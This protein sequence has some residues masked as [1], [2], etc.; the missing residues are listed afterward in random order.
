[1]ERLDRIQKGVERDVLEC[2]ERLFERTAV[3]AVGVGEHGERAAPRAADR[4]DR[5]LERQRAEVD[6]G[7][8]LDPLGR[9][10]ALVLHVE[11][12]S[13]QEVPSRRV[14]VGD[15]RPHDDLAQARYGARRDGVEGRARVETLEGGGKLACRLRERD[16]GRCGP[17]DRSGEDLTCGDAHGHLRLDAKYS[18]PPAGSRERAFGSPSVAVT[19]FTPRVTMTST[20]WPAST[21][22]TG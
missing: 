20:T 5:G 16:G 19:T 6:R 8:L 11:E 4:L 9:E 3:G 1:M 2:G 7:E 15:V 12:P 13:E 21:S 22:T 14:D 18:R 10:V 17:Q